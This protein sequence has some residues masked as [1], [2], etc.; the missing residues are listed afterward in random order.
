MPHAYGRPTHGKQHLLIFDWDDTLFPR[1]EL[2]RCGI[3]RQ[4]DVP[5]HTSVNLR[6]LEDKAIQVLRVAHSIGDVLVISNATC[7]WLRYSAEQ[8]YPRVVQYMNSVKDMQVISARDRVG[9]HAEIHMW[10]VL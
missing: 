9:N 5:H 10:K 1:S 6:K 4:V 7:Q 8:F 3:Q 2:R